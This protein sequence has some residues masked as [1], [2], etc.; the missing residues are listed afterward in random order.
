MERM[1]II[2][3]NEVGKVPR[4][5]V[6]QFCTGSAGSVSCG[7]STCH[8]NYQASLSSKPQYPKEGLCKRV[9]FRV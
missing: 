5:S 9:G 1:G 3:K 8:P 7:A 2:T 6:F 4:N